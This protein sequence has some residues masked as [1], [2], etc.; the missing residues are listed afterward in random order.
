MNE[1]YGA[2]DHGQLIDDPVLNEVGK[3]H[4]KS[5][6]QVAVAWGLS[7][8]HSVIP[9]SKTPARIEQNLQGDFKL[10]D[11]DV[12][13]IA[14]IDKKLRFNDSSKDFGYNFFTDLEGKVSS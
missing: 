3:K 13:K 12:N 11:E 1:T 5:G 6:A 14:A 4:G 2:K 7:R 8:G 10:D 9:K